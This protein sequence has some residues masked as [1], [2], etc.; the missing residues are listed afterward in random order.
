MISTSK[1]FDE[2]ASGGRVP[3]SFTVGGVPADLCLQSAVA[4]PHGDSADL[5][6]TV[7]DAPLS[8]YASCCIDRKHALVTWSWRLLARRNCPRVSSVRLMDL[9]LPHDD[10]GRLC[11]LRGIVGG[12]LPKV[13]EDGS[14]FPPNSLKP[15][16]RELAVNKP[17]D[18]DSDGCGK[19]S[20]SQIPIWLYYGPGGGLWFGPEYSGWWHLR[21]CRAPR[22][23]EVTVTLPALDFAMMQGEEI[24]LPAFSMAS[25]RGDL[26]TGHNHLRRTIRD[27]F[28]GR[29]DGEPPV[30]LVTWQGLG[31][32]ETHHTEE[33]VRRELQAAAELGVECFTF[34]AG[35]YQA[36]DHRS[37]SG[38]VG[39]EMPWGERR[40]QVWFDTMGDYQPHPERFPSGID[41]F[42]DRLHANGMIFGLWFDTRVSPGADCYDDLQH[43]LTHPDPDALGPGRTFPSVEFFGTGLVDL[44]R[45][46]GRDWL[47][48]LFER[49][50]TRYRAEWIWIDMNTF[51][52]PL[53]WDC[54]EEPDRRGL[55]ELRFYQGVYEVFGRVLARHP[56]VRVETCGNGGMYIDLGMLRLSHSIWIDDY[57]GFEALGQPYDIDVNR[58]FRSALCEWLPGPLPQNSLYIPWEVVCSDETYDTIHYVSHF[59]G[60]L[61]FGQRVQKWKRA[62]VE[63]AARAVEAY[64]RVRAY[65]LGDYYPLFPLPETRDAWDGWQFHDPDADAGALILFR[66]PDCERRTETVEPGGLGDPEGYA[67]EVILGSAELEPSDGALRVTLPAERYAVI[68]YRKR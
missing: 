25:W 24:R 68:E 11:T 23:T 4:G 47:E 41:D 28:M 38:H 17:F 42:V 57:V 34:N 50:I 55:M 63:C 30:P 66:L 54:R 16:N 5:A 52:R 58:N 3:F 26:R 64:K 27:V 35:W 14:Q 8:V 18:L 48:E 12:R 51:P 36:P 65:T 1:L 56:N 59:A 40:P 67:F 13:R 19:S 15:W 33:G 53:Y 37:L 39:P 46:A 9:E 62:D 60:T 29:V 22:Y 2:I 32:Q 49:M 43:V 7:A 10:P 21:A 61:T 20:S 31:G 44:G 45:Q 6:W